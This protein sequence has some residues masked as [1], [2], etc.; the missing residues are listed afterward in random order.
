M[1]DFKP[2]GNWDNHR[3]LLEMALE[4][5]KDNPN[6]VLE[7]G[8]GEGSTN[9]LR[10]YCKENNRQLESYDYSKEWA[11]KY[12]AFHIDNWDN[13]DWS[14]KYSA[15]L[16]DESPGEQRHISIQKLNADILVIHDSEPVAVGYM[17]DRIWN[18]FKYRVDVQSPGAWA[19]AVSNTIDVTAWV[20]REK[21]GYKVS[22]F[23]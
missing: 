2:S 6:P 9:L 1:I 19:S 7:L 17:L 16:V 8:C 21:Y 22:D 3:V 10:A 15:V 4:A 12:N 5:T 20:G 11:D 13:F 23:R 14:K 18:L